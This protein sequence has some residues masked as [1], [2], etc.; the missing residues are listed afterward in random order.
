MP[1]PALFIFAGYEVNNDFLTQ[2]DGRMLC[3]VD[4]YGSVVVDLSM[5]TSVAGL[6]AACDLRALSH[7]KAVCVTGDGAAAAL[8]AIA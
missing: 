1:L 4:D 8:E 2:E 6:F 5:R 7:K 3:E